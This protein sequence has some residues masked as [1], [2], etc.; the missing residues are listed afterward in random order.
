M[1]INGK[2]VHKGRGEFKPFVDALRS[3]Q[4]NIWVLDMSIPKKE[5]RYKLLGNNRSSNA[6][7][8]AFTKFIE[9]IEL[10]S[11]DVSWICSVQ[12]C[13]YDMRLY[14]LF[15]ENE[16]T[17]Y[18]Q[19]TKDYCF[20]KGRIEY[21]HLDYFKGELLRGISHLRNTIDYDGLNDMYLG[22]D[23]HDGAY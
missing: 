20:R 13:M 17:L 2:E 14:F 5:Y 10:S 4:G 1:L 7:T 9:A 18:N 11:K 3:A 19:A 23:K 6:I 21:E 15:F 8:K 16:P 12:Y 22:L